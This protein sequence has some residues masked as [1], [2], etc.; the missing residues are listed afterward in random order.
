L[1]FPL[2]HLPFP[3]S[4]AWLT[5]R[6]MEP[7]RSVSLVPFFPAT[8][9]PLPLPNTPSRSVFSDPFFWGEVGEIFGHSRSVSESPK[10]PPSIWHREWVGSFP[11]SAGFLAPSYPASRPWSPVQDRRSPFDRFFPPRLFLHSFSQLRCF[12][13]RNPQSPLLQGNARKDFPI[14]LSLP[15]FPGP[16][17]FFKNTPPSPAPFFEVGVFL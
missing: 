3:F 16:V 5:E 8:D 1:L 14:A 17:F 9:F 2:G 12:P 11:S 6:V 15:L 7:E 13:S 4:F 10:K